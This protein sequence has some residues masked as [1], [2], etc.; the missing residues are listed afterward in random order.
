MKRIPPAIQ[1]N[2]RYL[3]FKVRGEYKE[4]GEVVDAVWDSATKYMG[5]QG[6]SKCDL[7]IIGNKF[8]EEKQEGVVKINREM[9]DDFRAALTLNTGFDDDTFLSVEKA[10]GTLKSL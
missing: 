6:A 8:D 2:Q 9:E 10:S 7:W 4:I 5:T 1:E 3:K